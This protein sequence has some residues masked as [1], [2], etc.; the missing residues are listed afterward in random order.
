MVTAQ[1]MPS[2]VPTQPSGSSNNS[3]KAESP[4]RLFL[5]LCFYT[6]L[7]SFFKAVQYDINN[8]F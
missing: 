3:V 2:L 5:F 8:I 4:Q 7:K 1:A 6:N